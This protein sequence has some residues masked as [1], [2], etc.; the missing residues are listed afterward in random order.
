MVLVVLSNLTLTRL[1]E[2]RVF[3][4]FIKFIQYDKDELTVQT[5]ECFLKCSLCNHSK[6]EV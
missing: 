6:L 5:N 1:F 4:C 3:K 2:I